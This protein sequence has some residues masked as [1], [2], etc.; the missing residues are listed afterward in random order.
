[1]NKRGNHGH[2]V[3]VFILLVQHSYFN[4]Q[5]NLEMFAFGKT[6]FYQVCG[7][8]PLIKRIEGRRHS[9]Q[10][11]GCTC[12]KDEVFR[13]DFPRK[14]INPYPF[15]ICIDIVLNV[16][17]VKGIINIR[18]ALIKNSLNCDK[19]LSEYLGYPQSPKECRAGGSEHRRRAVLGVPLQTSTEL[20]N[21][22]SF[23]D[24]VYI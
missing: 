20:T 21:S 18:P 2:R 9:A 11:P 10:A 13:K 7:I 3:A 1:L 15:A 14:R 12:V 8:Y 16:L 17:K 24:W 4:C 5:R 22:E 6:G 23:G 19:F